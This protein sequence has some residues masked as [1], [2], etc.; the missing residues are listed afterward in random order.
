MDGIVGFPLVLVAD[1][2]GELSVTFDVTDS[3]GNPILSNAA[4]ATLNDTRHGVVVDADRVMLP[5]LWRM[6]A[7]GT[8]LRVASD[9]VVGSPTPGALSLWTVVQQVASHYGEGVWTVPMRA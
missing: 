2:P 1:L 6:V 9:I 7:R 3:L 5:G 4:G 8:R